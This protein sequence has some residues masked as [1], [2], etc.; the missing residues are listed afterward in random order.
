VRELEN[1]FTL[2]PLPNEIIR[3]ERLGGVTRRLGLMKGFALT[4][5]NTGGTGKVKVDLWLCKGRLSG[6]RKS[7]C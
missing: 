6:G 2:W 7:G 4:Q 1:I 5:D 3:K